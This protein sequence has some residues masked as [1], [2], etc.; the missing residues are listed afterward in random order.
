MYRSL[1]LGIA[2]LSLT[3]A[4]EASD[5]TVQFSGRIMDPG[6]RALFAP[7]QRQLQI[8]Q[9]PD[10]AQ[11][12]KVSFTSMDTGTA[13]SLRSGSNSSRQITLMAPATQPHDTSFSLRLHLD[14]QTPQVMQGSY[15]VDIDYL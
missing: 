6:C 10:S 1:L 3:T 9:C 12:A 15:L 7:I 13:L 4:A 8:E 14:A 2:L 5:G 11:G